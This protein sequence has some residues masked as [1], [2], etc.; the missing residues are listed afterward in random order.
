M[1]SNFFSPLLLVSKS[2]RRAELLK[3]AG[4]QFESY[5]LE[6][7]EIVN[8]NLNPSEQVQ[9][10]ACFKM[11]QFLESF[12][13]SRSKYSFA[14]TF[15]TMVEFE[16]ENLGKP[17]DKNEALD[18]LLKYSGKTQNVHTGCCI[19]QFK[20]D[21]QKSWVSTT[22][23]I[24]KNINRSAALAYLDNQPSFI[25]KAGGYG[26]QDKNFN[27]VERIEGEYSNV[28]GLP[29]KKLAE[30]LQSEF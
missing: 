30:E 12:E 25:D 19:Y 2:P 26:L 1:N 10:L 24:F 28:V 7:S 18:W 15:D 22:K 20:N 5:T 29:L 14:M 27:L 13:G 8:K 3:K 16:S 9:D 4:Y 23:V 6:I 17:K 21:S 11:K